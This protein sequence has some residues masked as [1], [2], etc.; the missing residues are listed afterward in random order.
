MVKEIE[1][2]AVL[3]NILGSGEAYKNIGYYLEE[4][5]Y[6][7]MLGDATKTSEGLQVLKNIFYYCVL[8]TDNEAKKISKLIYLPGNHD[9][10]LYAYA[11]SKSAESKKYLESIPNGKKVIEEINKWYEEDS[12]ELG[13]FINWLGSLPLQVAFKSGN[14]NFF[15]AHAFFNKTQYEENSN[16]SLSD[17]NKGTP[18]EIMARIDIL[19]LKPRN[20]T[21]YK[22]KDVPDGEVLIGHTTVRGGGKIIDQYSLHN[23]PT[24]P[25]EGKK[26]R[27]KGTTIVH[28]INGAALIKA[29]EILK[30][31]K[32]KRASKPLISIIM[33]IL[34]QRNTIPSIE[35]SSKL[36]EGTN[37][38]YTLNE[39]LYTKLSFII[40]GGVSFIENNSQN[41]HTLDSLIAA[42]CEQISKKDIEELD[43]DEK[44]VKYL[45]TYNVLL[46]LTKRLLMDKFGNSTATKKTIE[47]VL[48]N[49][50]YINTLCPKANELWRLIRSNEALAH[51]FYKERENLIEFAQKALEEDNRQDNGYNQLSNFNGF[52][53]E[54]ALDKRKNVKETIMQLLGGSEEIPL[55]SKRFNVATIR[56]DLLTLLGGDDTTSTEELIDEFL[57]CKWNNSY[58]EKAIEEIKS[59]VSLRPMPYIILPINFL[60]R[61]DIIIDGKKAQK[62]I[63]ERII[64]VPSYN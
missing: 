30:N 8:S 4:Y 57:D 56:E 14:K 38:A 17:I 21:T 7:F 29:G 32:I 64:G 13:L 22:L 1:N 48:K 55:T 34:A 44:D 11:V 16:L 63:K 25:V 26:K 6:V 51:E 27:E 20:G 42:Y 10:Q 40:E 45:I 23:K 39:E 61:C 36:P 19:N 50:E 15:L 31:N 60:N 62:I 59:W 43:I 18:E 37:R 28:C 35:V 9:R 47:G 41:N 5:P 2:C 58:L 53:D 12:D 49:N 54:I 24:R 52:V 46:R 3:T 33:E